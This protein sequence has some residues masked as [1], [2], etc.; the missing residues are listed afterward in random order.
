M[1]ANHGEITEDVL[2]LL[3]ADLPESVRKP[4][5]FSAGA[6]SLQNITVNREGRTDP[7]RDLSLEVP[8]GARIGIAGSS[9]T[10]KSTLLDVMAGAIA[11]DAGCVM[12]G[13]VPL[14]RSSGHAWR[15]RI[16]FVSQHPILLGASLR[17]AVIFPD[18]PAQADPFRL[19][20]AIRLAG[21]D[22]MAGTFARGLDTAIGEVAE[23]LSGGQRQ[24]LALAHALY[25]ARDLLLL[26]EATGHLD[27]VS[28]LELVETIEA[29]P[30]DLTI[31]LVSHRPAMF[32]CCD[33]VYEL[34][35]GR[36]HERVHAARS[37]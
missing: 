32:R 20:E 34:R 25:R 30:R 6:I 7:L 15:E 1:I 19:N 21:V 24:R 11:P 3:S 36:L 35:E 37:A 18:L 33:K 31:V 17:E 8:R 16:G 2:T 27:P 14:D 5:D 13:R 29:L 28:E 22:L 4:A 23:Q 9:G 12:I 26:D 10:G